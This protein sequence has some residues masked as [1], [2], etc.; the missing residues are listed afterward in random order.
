MLTK[1][2]FDRLLAKFDPDPELAGEKYELV[3]ARIIKF[4]ECHGASSPQELAD[5]TINRVARKISEDEDIP[6]E[7]MMAYC[8]GVARNVLHE[9]KRNPGSSA[10]A[11]DS[12]PPSHHPSENPEDSIQKTVERSTLEQRLACLE[13]CVEKL[14]PE[15]REMVQLYYLT[16]PG[17]KIASRRQLAEALHIPINNLRIRIYR[18]RARLIKCLHDCL[19]RSKLS[20]K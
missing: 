10:S 19:N 6:S 12:L 3:R 4:F 20:N 2:V 5:E 8:Y 14:P 1:E 13:T 9:E 16:K 7:S 18:V 15:T 11:I 17:A